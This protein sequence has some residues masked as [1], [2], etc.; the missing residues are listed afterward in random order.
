MPFFPLETYIDGPIL[1]FDLELDLAI[2]E[3]QSPLAFAR[4]APTIE[5]AGNAPLALAQNMVDCRGD[6]RQYVTCLT[7]WHPCVKSAGKFFGDEAGGKLA[8]LPAGMCHQRRKKR[9][10]VANAVDDKSVECVALRIDRR[11]TRRG[12]RHQLRNHRVIEK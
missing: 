11:A 9:H 12:M 5:L 8:G 6:S 3:P 4:D 10:I 7:L 1:A 2:A